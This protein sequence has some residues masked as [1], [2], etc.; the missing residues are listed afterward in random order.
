MID[1][2]ELAVVF[3]LETLP[4]PQHTAGAAADGG[5]DWGLVQ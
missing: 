5:N 1:G 4:K 3:A 2:L